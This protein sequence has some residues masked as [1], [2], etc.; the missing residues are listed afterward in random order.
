MSSALQTL[1]AWGVLR[2]ALCMV[3]SVLPAKASATATGPSMA[4]YYGP[5]PPLTAL[6]AFDRVVLEPDNAAPSDVT[7]LH[8]AGV[9]VLAY[10]SV[11][12]AHQRRPWF[13]GLEAAWKLGGPRAPVTPWGGVVMDPAQAGWRNLLVEQA[14]R[15]R[16]LGYQ[17]LFLDTLD[18][19]ERVF[20]TE[21][22]RQ[23]RVRG[24]L[25][26]LA[27]LRAQLPT[28]TLVFNRGFALFPD[29]APFAAGM[30]AESLFAGYDPAGARYRPVPGADRAWLLP[31]LQ[32]IR[33][34]HGI[35]VT[36]IDYLPEGERGRAREVAR[37][38]AALGLT[39][40]VTTA[41]L[42]RVG[43]GV[44]EPV[45]RRALLVYDSA[46]GPLAAS[47]AHAW[48][49]LPLEHLGFAVDY[50]DA[51]GALLPGRL[52]EVYA[53][54]VTV[55][56]DDA[57]AA[58]ARYQR[59]LLQQLDA[60]VRVAIIGQ[61]G[62]PPEPPFLA[63]L[64]LQP[65]EGALAPPASIVRR[66]GLLDFEATAYPLLD[67]L[68][69][70]RAVG[71]GMT[72]HL[73]VADRN[74]RR[75]HPVLTAPWGGMALAPYLL[76]PRDNGRLRWIVDP[77]AF[78]AR[79]LAPAAPALDLT[80]ENGRRLLTVQID[81][82]G[83]ALVS[84]TPRRPLAAQV[85]LDEVL[86]AYG[87]PTAVALDEAELGPTGPHAKQSPKLQ[88]VAR[89]ILE[90]PTVEPVPPAGLRVAGGSAPAD[91]EP[92][93]SLTAITCLGR[94]DG[95]GYQVYAPG[96]DETSYTDLWRGPFYGYRRV[97]DTFKLTDRPRRLKPIAIH[98]HF[99]SG[100]KPAG[101]AALRTV[102]D[103]ALAE[104]S[105]PISLAEYAQKVQ[106]FRRATLARTLDGGWELRHLGPLRTIRFDAALGWPDLEASPD[107]I[108]LRELP[109]G[110]Y[111]TVR[112]GESVRVKFR[113]QPPA[114]PYLEW[115]NGRVAAWARQDATVTLR[116]VGELPL[117]AALGACSGARATADGRPLA[118]TQRQDTAHLV[119]AGKESGHVVV[120]CH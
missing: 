20:P 109:Q 111:L 104:E 53:A 24:L 87:L 64:G 60:G 117:R 50:M 44:V 39:P 14:R 52:D 103:W 13:A 75:A 8:R 34:R 18:S 93:R 79:A 37:Q 85:I 49:A 25:A 27:A 9:E 29:A 90:L 55:F 63:R 16:D 43:V 17:G 40:W 54:I 76:E 66:D 69:P 42:D 115:A 56:T 120:T 77:F 92:P 38:I 106:G 114:R 45:P 6:G 89:Q 118:V 61:L 5:H 86:R 62:F 33:D 119:F 95:D 116:L 48:L 21:A 58:P 81:G 99:Y 41:A 102:Y 59:W 112:D 47:G 35:P 4:F 68:R 101:L 110:R 73:E 31:R 32:G 70:L 84:E 67:G 98:H 7:A 30:V 11:G 74:G 57:L 83:F 51:R 107:V 36:V 15:L 80:T 100:A 88:A 1:H 78:L 71:P 2:L 94:P 3:V 82:D 113:A 26:L 12:E 23:P 105:L 96:L 108:G 22:E 91:S 65:A 97:L 28:L 10:L 46:E 72:V 19:Y